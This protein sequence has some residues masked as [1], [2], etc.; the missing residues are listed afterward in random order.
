MYG[1]ITKFH[2]SLEVGIIATED[3]RKFRFNKTEVVN[4]NGR[5]AGQEVD[6]IV[7]SAGLRPSDIILLAGTPWQVFGHGKLRQG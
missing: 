6:F 7:A 3:G 2:E 4:L 1:Q 5:L